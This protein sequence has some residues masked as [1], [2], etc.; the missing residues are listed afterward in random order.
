M[1][2]TCVIFFLFGM[3]LYIFYKK[4]YKKKR[5]KKQLNQKALE[6]C[7]CQKA[8]RSQSFTFGQTT[9]QL[10]LHQSEPFL[11]LPEGSK[12]WKHASI[13][14]MFETSDCD[15][16]N[17]NSQFATYVQAVPLSQKFSTSSFDE[18][19]DQGTIYKV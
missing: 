8:L 19:L 18:D 15:T 3:L 13:I 9:P 2:V 17:K 11:P 1:I 4:K 12:T 10:R 7:E 16:I 14:E 6:F 5:G